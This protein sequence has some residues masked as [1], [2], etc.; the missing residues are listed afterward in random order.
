MLVITESEK[1]IKSAEITYTIGN[2]I[3]TSDELFKPSINYSIC[4][5]PL[6]KVATDGYFICYLAVELDPE[7]D[8]EVDYVVGLGNFALP[9]KILIFSRPSSLG[10]SIGIATVSVLLLL[11]SAVGFFY[12]KKRMRFNWNVEADSVHSSGKF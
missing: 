4:I 7:Q 6:E 12:V 9:P 10:L 2:F 1:N 11:L 5:E 8:F 3:F